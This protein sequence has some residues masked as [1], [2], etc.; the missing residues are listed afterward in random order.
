MSI[1]QSNPRQRSLRVGIYDQDTLTELP[2]EAGEIQDCGGFAHA[3]FEICDG[4]NAIVWLV[5]NH[6]ASCAFIEDTRR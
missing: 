4:N 5:S 3:A 1:G 6:K 2:N